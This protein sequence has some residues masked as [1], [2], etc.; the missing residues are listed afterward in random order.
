[1]FFA[2]MLCLQ[3]L[4]LAQDSFEGSLDTEINISNICPYSMTFLYHLGLLPVYNCRP[5][6]ALMF[7]MCATR[8]LFI[9]F[10]GGPQDL[11]DF[12]LGDLSLR[13]QGGSFSDI[14][15][16]VSANSCIDLS[17][18]MIKSVATEVFI[19]GQEAIEDIGQISH[20][21][22]GGEGFYLELLCICFS[23]DLG[24]IQ[25]ALGH[26]VLYIALGFMGDAVVPVLDGNGMFV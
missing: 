7:P 1:M 13:V 22:F 23:L 24:D 8:D 4:L 21:F 19:G 18:G 10:D 15:K 12:Y 14:G 9:I 20:V 6:G 5:S 3:F 25:V 17:V 16:D 26:D 11:V 2:D